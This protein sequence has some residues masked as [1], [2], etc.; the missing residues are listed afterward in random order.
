MK[1]IQMAIESNPIK[2]KN[3]RKPE[4]KIIISGWIFHDWQLRCKR[5]WGDSHHGGHHGGHHGPAVIINWFQLISIFILK[6]IID[7]NHSRSM[8]WRL[9][10][11]RRLSKR[12]I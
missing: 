7:A 6:L 5:R 12:R 2:N 10:T 9:L 11:G 3:E 4:M 8:G 1:S